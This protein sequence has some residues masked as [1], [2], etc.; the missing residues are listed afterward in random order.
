VVADP[1]PQPTPQPGGIILIAGKSI[2]L[3]DDA[4]HA[5]TVLTVECRWGQPCP[6]PPLDTIT[7]GRSRITVSRP[8]GQIVEEHIA[9]GEEGAFDWLREALRDP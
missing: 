4:Y 2:R 1:G 8:T 6:Q 3:P 7:R 5:S 9:P